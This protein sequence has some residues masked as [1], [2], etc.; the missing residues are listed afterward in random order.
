MK[1]NRSM[2]IAFAG[3]ATLIFVATF[4]YPIIRTIVMSFF[5]IQEIT[6]A[7][8]KWKFNGIG[9]YISLMETPLYRTSWINLFKIF[10]IGGVIT[11]GA[12][13]LL[14]VILK[15]GVH[16]KRFFQAAIYLP[17]VISAVAMA[18]MWIQYV[19]NSSYGF[20]TNL[21]KAL[22]LDF[23]ADVQWLDADHK[24]WALLISYCF[25]MIGHFM[26]IWVS[27][28]E[29]IGKDYYE[30]ASIDGANK[31]G[32]LLY[33]TLPLLKGIFRTNVIM[34]SISVSGFFIWSKLFSPIS[35]DT[36]TIV[37]MVYMYDKLF[38]AENTGDVVRDAGTAAAI[39]VMLCLFIVLVF[40]VVNRLI[41]DDDLEF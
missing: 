17:N 25:G 24:F 34:W 7:T 12:S 18:T 11:L 33:I 28:I 39:G 19:F 9:N 27:G 5:S 15:S 41:K 26:L 37:P 10:I 4:I 3:P 6:D 32:Q 38:G 29:R 20:L 23:L 13:L 22:H 36:S 8:D 2:I 30:A 31:V 40:T 14:A 16:G 21:F 1:R 35:A